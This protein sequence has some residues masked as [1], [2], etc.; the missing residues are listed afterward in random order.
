[1]ISTWLE[2]LL[3]GCAIGFS[4][5]FLSVFGDQLA[6]KTKMGHSFIG[7]T[8]I[9]AVTSFPELGSGIGA[10]T[11]ANSS[12]LAA[13]GI[14]GSC[15]FNVFILCI[16]DLLHRKKSIYQYTSATQLPLGILGILFLG[17]SGFIVSLSYSPLQFLH[18]LGAWLSLPL[19]IAYI[20]FLTNYS[21]QEV[22][23][24]KQDK[25][26]QNPASPKLAT[27]ILGFVISCLFVVASGLYLPVVGEKLVHEMAWSESFFGTLLLAI[28]TSLPELAVTLSSLSIGAI[29]MALAN[30]WG[31]NLFNLAI[32]WIFDLLMQ[33][34]IFAQISTTHLIS[35]MTSIVMS[36][37]A[38]IG[39]YLKPKKNL[40][41]YLSWPNFLMV[42]LYF[43]TL[44]SLF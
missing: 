2:F 38:M 30:I 7:L 43:L 19:F 13:G 33:G 18:L 10:I 9:A 34:S 11:L 23:A 6:Q 4:G 36:G 21:N 32:L 1:M 39:I 26:S 20:V 14:F 40:G 3:C 16:L 22:A 29:D 44:F 5:Y 41:L 27:M 12:D 37:L 15:M 28:S 8:L 31:S 17:Y 25:E 42:I 35:I 24:N